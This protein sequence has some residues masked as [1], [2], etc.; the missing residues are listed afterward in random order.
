MVDWIFNQIEPREGDLLLDLCSGSGCIG[1][2]CKKRFPLLQVISVDLSK[3][4]IE[5]A[6]ENSR[7]NKTDIR[8]IHGDFLASL[9]R[10]KADF[11][12]CNPPYLS[13]NEYLNVQPSVHHFEPKMALVGGEKGV[14]YYQ[15]MASELPAFL[16]P[17]AKVFLEIGFSQKSMIENIFLTPHWKILSVQKDWS[18]QD[19]FFF[20][21]KQ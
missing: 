13:D 16:N 1:I 21:E 7:I 8:F 2:A 9:A 12:I 20:L 17:K 5:L 11:V 18:G 14:E 6:L 19:R 10:I 4:A 3:D 15:R